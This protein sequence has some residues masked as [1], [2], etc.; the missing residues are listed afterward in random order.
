MATSDAS[1]TK[2]SSLVQRLGDN[3]LL[4]STNANISNDNEEEGKLPRENRRKTGPT[5]T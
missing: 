5:V 4:V 1:C 2:Q 3:Q